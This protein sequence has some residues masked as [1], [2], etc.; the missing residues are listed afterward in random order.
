MADSRAEYTQHLDVSMFMARESKIQQLVKEQ[1]A[2]RKSTGADDDDSELL[3]NMYSERLASSQSNI[4]RD[5]NRILTEQKVQ[6]Q[7]SDERDAERIDT[8]QEGVSQL[9]ENPPMIENLSKERLLAAL[10][11]DSLQLPVDESITM[12]SNV[13]KSIVPLDLRDILINA[14]EFGPSNNKSDRE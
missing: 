11:D 8:S 9:F 7:Q 6:Q 5:L 1:H 3:E 4:K 14:Q 12:N 13:G 2:K 10:Q